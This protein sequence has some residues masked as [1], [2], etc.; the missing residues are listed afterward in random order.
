MQF[1][2][3]LNEAQQKAVL[4]KDGPL[5]IVAG[6]GAG[7]TKT[8]VH[9]ICNLVEEGITPTAILAVTF[10]NKAA[11]E[12]RERVLVQLETLPAALRPNGIPFVSTFHSLGVFL[13]RRFGA[14]GGEVKRFTILDD[15]D[16]M[17]LI[18]ESLQYF[19]LDPKTN[20]PRAIR[21]TISRAANALQT[22]DQL[23]KDSNP[24]N[25]MAGQ[26][27]KRY[28]ALK[29]EQ[30]SLDFDDLLL[31][32]VKLLEENETVRAWC[33]DT[34]H[35][36]H[37]DEYQDT[38]EVQYRIAKA[39]AGARKNLCVVGDSDQSIYSWRGANIKNILE[40]ER[41]YPEATV[42]LLEENYRSTKT[43]IAAANVIVNKNTY[44]TPK[45]LFTNNEEG[46]LIS[47]YAAYDENDEAKFIAE[48]CIEIMD[49]GA[50]ADDIAILFR[51]NFQSRA[52]EEAL[53]SYSVPYQVLGVK[54]FERKEVKDVLS[55]IRA[56]QNPDSIVDLK[57]II[58]TPVRGIGKVTI[59]KYFV[60][61]IEGLSGKAAISVRNFFDML[62]KI[63]DFAD[64]H[65][66]SE[67]IKYIIVESGMQRAYKED[68][69]DGEE[70]LEN[71]EELVTLGLRYDHLE[72][73][74]GLEKLLEDATLMSDQD[75][76]DKDSGSGKNKK[77]AE[78][79]GVKLMTIHAAKGLE[80]GTVFVTGLEHGLFP[81]QR[82]ANL[83]G[84]D[85]EEE[86]RLMYVAVTRARRKLYLTYASMR[87]IFG[88]RDVRLPSEF[89]MDVPDEYIQRESRSGEAGFTVFL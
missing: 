45:Q 11:K 25:R 19:G 89:L 82:D 39:L 83:T 36:I 70:R 35:Y 86:R 55:Y 50:K 31:E 23:L 80:F 65:S 77:G 64:L 85:A 20:E 18:K 38:N 22:P 12:M 76:L 37:V 60:H 81:H 87:T 75:N 41:D 33:H 53:L 6:A 13:L 48:R 51:T 56:A 24:R 47:V 21:S 14:Y 34:W 4:S 8:I 63:R 49:G 72:G 73:Y 40:F 3:G 27:W 26:V 61:G 30:K 46:E 68:K 43:V 29:R 28:T 44:R 88:M 5:L 2:E 66:V 84:A 17:S 59:D 54:F 16:T 15:A 79:H 67:T 10:T 7:K 42:V 1:L 69:I 32:T 58:N 71:L 57:R 74:E 78:K 9:R 52:I 62:E